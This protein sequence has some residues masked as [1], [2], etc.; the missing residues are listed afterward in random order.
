MYQ[1]IG[2]VRARREN[3]ITPSQLDNLRSHRSLQTH[4]EPNTYI[5]QMT[6]AN[7]KEDEETGIPPADARMSAINISKC[8][9]AKS[10]LT[11]WWVIYLNFA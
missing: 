11:S 9:R 6:T 4:T 8:A 3:I 2:G 1:I 7:T 5:L 10:T